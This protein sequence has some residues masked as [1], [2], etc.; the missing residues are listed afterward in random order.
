MGEVRDLVRSAV[1]ASDGLGPEATC[2]DDLVQAVDEAVTNVIRH[3]YAGDTGWVEVGIERDGDRFIVV[4][5]DEA[6]SFDPT[7]MEAPD[8]RVAPERRRPGGMG[9]HLMRTA[10]DT[11]VHRPRP[12]G[13]NILTMTRRIVRTG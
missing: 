6:R 12:G 2:R 5:E 4:V 8:L 11:I 13:G 1:E 10:T 7:T 9:V 3:G